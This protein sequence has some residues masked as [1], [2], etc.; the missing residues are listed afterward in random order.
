MTVKL[1]KAGTSTDLMISNSKPGKGKH[2][3]KK[4]LSDT[5]HNEIHQNS[6]SIM[7]LDT[8]GKCHLC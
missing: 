8:Y 7:I 5:Q 3:E 1:G 6:L 4:W 2:G